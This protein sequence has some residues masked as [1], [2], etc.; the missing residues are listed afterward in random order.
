MIAIGNGES[1]KDI[2]IPFHSIGCNA[3]HRDYKIE[4][5][6]CVDPKSLYEAVSSA[7]T[8][9]TKIYT[10]NEWRSSVD[11][12]KVKS[13]PV[14]PYSGT[15]SL[16]D[17]SHWGSGPYAVLLASMLSEKI[18]LIGFD[19]YSDNGFVNNIYKDTLNYDSSICY[20]PDPAFT[21]YQISRVI[22]HFKHK[23]YVIYNKKD[24]IMPKDWYAENVELKSIDLFQ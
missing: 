24:W 11:S 19:L 8:T 18:E 22:K 2:A 1:R 9:D 17:P 13:V 15:S 14:L 3:I 6:I 16:D 10:R 4:H 7:N 23:Y 12:Q 5:L 21:I 20:Q